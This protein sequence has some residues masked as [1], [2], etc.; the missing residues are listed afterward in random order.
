MSHKSFTVMIVKNFSLGFSFTTDAKNASISCCAES[1][2]TQTGKRTG[3]TLT[4]DLSNKEHLTNLDWYNVK[5]VCNWQEQ[6]FYYQIAFRTQIH[7]SLLDINV[8][9]KVFENVK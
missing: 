3:P 6:A 8:D 9:K 7:F 4:M 2:M 5:A 1:A